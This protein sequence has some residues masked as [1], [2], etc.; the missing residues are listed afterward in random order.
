MSRSDS[1]PPPSGAAHAA[2]RMCGK[3]VP[4]SSPESD[5]SDWE[6][7]PASTNVAESQVAS[8]P[9]HG[10]RQEEGAIGVVLDAR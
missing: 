5:A 2:S 3:S 10:R 7:T 8:S 4:R 1:H 6:T 9:A